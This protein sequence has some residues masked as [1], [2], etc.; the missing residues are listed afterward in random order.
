[1]SR[2]AINSIFGLIFL[3]ASAFVNSKG[4]ECELNNDDLRLMKKALVSFVRADGSVFKLQV[5]L[6]DNNVTRAAGFQYVCES[7]I[8]DEPILFVFQNELQ[9]RFHMNNVVAPLDIA[10]IDKDGSVESVQAMQP[11]ILI[12]N[13]RPLYSP[14][15]PIIAALEGHQGFYDKHKLGL[16]TKVT[17]HVL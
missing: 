1:M 11:Y 7:T 15:R 2:T 8:E 16:D 17:W 9:P 12:S 13:H 14:K 5:K 4:I 6:A 10:F 3:L